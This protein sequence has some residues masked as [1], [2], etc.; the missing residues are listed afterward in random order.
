MQPAAARPQA[1]EPVGRVI[2]RA[3]WQRGGP[4]LV[5][6]AGIHGNETAGVEALQRVVGRLAADPAG[7]RGRLVALAGNRGAL[8]RGCRFVERDLNRLWTPEELER[9][10]KK[11]VALKAEERELAELDSELRRIFCG[12]EAP[13]YLL[14]LHST[15]GDGPPFTIL[16]DTLPNRRLALCLPV[17]VVLGMEEELEGTLTHH[18]SEEGVA[19][20]VFEAGQ[21]R[22]PASVERAAAAV[23]ITLESV[24]VLARGSRPEV[25]AARGRLERKYGDLPE[26][27]E[28]RYRHG[29]TAVDQFRMT[30]G[31]VSFEAVRAGQVLGVDRRGPVAA[32][33][34]GR[35]LMPLYQPQGDEGFFL[36]REVHPFWLR[37]SAAVR[38]LRFERWIHCLPG[39]HRHPERPGCFVVDR[40]VARWV[41][42]ELFH[43]LGFHRVGPPQRHVVMSRRP[44]DR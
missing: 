5:C 16:D 42:L 20:V 35:L 7:L 10:R 17:P 43:L 15:S 28:V 18:L 2:G 8:A 34:D 4:V 21:H 1:D 40:R 26:V 41:A 36:I 44:H 33:G 27:V 19:N 32:P 14:D 25:A 13:V 37:I 38:R 22:A 11:G 23:W 3:G 30:P 29:I 24:G 39:V 6:V 9:V 31:F 12:S